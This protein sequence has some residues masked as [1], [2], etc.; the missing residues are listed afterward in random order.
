MTKLSHGPK[1]FGK[2]ILEGVG[3][4]MLKGQLSQLVGNGRGMSNVRPFIEV[5]SRGWW[6]SVL[7]SVIF[8]FG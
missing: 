8:P 4:E 2:Y 1:I 7:L 5:G 3:R 6:E